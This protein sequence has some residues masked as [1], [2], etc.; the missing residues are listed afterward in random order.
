MKSFNDHFLQTTQLTLIAS[1]VSVVVAVSLILIK[2]FALQS[3]NSVGLLASLVDSLLDLLAS[4]I[5]LFAVRFALTPADDEHRFGHGKAESLASLGQSLFI[6]SSAVFLMI[7]TFDRVTNPQKLVELDIGIGAIVLSTLLTLALVLFQSF[8]VKKTGSLAIK[9][10]M[11]HYKTDLL[12]N[13]A[14]LGALVLAA[15]DFKHADTAV[16]LLIGVY[17]MECAIK[18]AY[19][20]IQMLLDRE[21]PEEIHHTITSIAQ[22]QQQVAAIHDIRTRQSGHTKFIQFHLVLDGD[23]PLKT[24]HQIAESVEKKLQSKHQNA[25]ILIH[26]EP[27]LKL[28]SASKKPM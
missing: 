13:L 4:V 14:I 18:L 2:F 12:T 10:D 26:L 5:N 21:L 9:G 11:L 25:D 19:E 22:E 15:L 27:D 3:S 1:R 17:I 16:A 28:S 6:I 23:L 20:S 8:V 24:A 7:Y